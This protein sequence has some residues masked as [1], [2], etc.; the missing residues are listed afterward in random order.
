M[1]INEK[2]QKSKTAFLKYNNIINFL[3]KSMMLPNVYFTN[4][5]K[6]YSHDFSSFTKLHSEFNKI[7]EKEVQPKDSKIKLYELLQMN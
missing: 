6:L 1:E 5:V 4:E 3:E 7:Y 2:F